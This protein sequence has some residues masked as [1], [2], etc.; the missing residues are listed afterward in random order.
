[1]LTA[2]AVAGTADP[3][4]T[5]S[6]G[7]HLERTRFG[8]VLARPD[9]SLLALQGRNVRSFAADG[10]PDP[11]FTSPQAPAEGRLFPVAGGKT[12]ALGYRKLTRLNPDGS[13]DRSFGRD[14]TVAVYGTQAVYELASGKIAL[15]STEVNGAKTIY[16]AVRVELLNQDGSAA[17]G[18]AFTAPLATPNISYAEV[19]AVPEI[20]PTGDGGALVVGTNFLLKLNAD[21]SVDLGFGKGGV[22]GDASGLVGGHVLADGSI[23]T[24]GVAREEGGGN[25]LVALAR[26]SA[27]G[28][29]ETSF[30]S[31]GAR[32]FDLGGGEVQPAAASWGA[33]GSVVVGGRI[34]ETPG[35]CPEEGCR[36]VPFL[37]AFDA[38]GELESGFAQGGVL[39]LS[40]LAGVT[41][42]YAAEGVTAMTRRPDGSIVV[43]GNAPPNE[44]TGF[45][46]AASPQGALLPGFGEGG[47]AREPEPLRASQEVAGFVPLPDGG[48]LA[49][50]STDVGIAERPVLIRYGSDDRLDR[51]F[52]GGAGYLP[53]WTA[54]DSS[55]DGATGFATNGEEVLVG[56]YDTPSS[57]LFMAHTADGSPVASFGAEGTVDLPPET[58]AMQPAFAVDGDPLVLVHHRVAGPA[59]GEPGVVLRYRPDGTLD[60]GFGHGGQVTMLLGRK[61]VRGKAILTGPGERILVGGSLGHRFAIASLLPDGALDRHF[62]AGGW[63]VVKLPEATHY[64]TMSRIGRWIYVAGTI[65][66]ENAKGDLVLM[67]FDRNG[68]LD[69]SFGRDGRIVDPLAI[70]AHPVNVIPTPQGPLVVL[71]GG[72]RPLVT[73]TRGGKVRSRPVSG[74]PGF[75]S[76]VRAAVS[77]DELILGWVT[78]SRADKAEVYH[79]TRRPL[80]RP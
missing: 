6:L 56:H 66:D 14:G 4:A 16:A 75:V 49:A 46:A 23:E 35:P 45:L 38:A 77:G 60:K 24:V 63:A 76:D 41:E 22:M 68:H 5:E 44:T 67:R 33:D 42:G 39:K 2:P 43:A 31:D 61:P 52:G 26:Y 18:K 71:G 1:M 55:P 13:V 59:A 32:R 10:S 17:P 21:G 15:V 40:T 8:S 27:A 78:Y 65:G 3:T 64:L 36:E 58:W 29:P 53:L 28:E 72:K 9:G 51:S 11:A 20:S 79:L 74:A 54:P 70:W 37:A 50:G 48:L 30:G 7:T 47:I 62:G 12:L 34:G 73:F 80:S 57:H 25:D 69:R 19:V